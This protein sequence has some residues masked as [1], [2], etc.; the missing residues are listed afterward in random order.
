VPC[1][2]RLIQAGCEFKRWVAGF[3]EGVSALVRTIGRTRVE[4][5]PRESVMDE[6]FGEKLLQGLERVE[7]GA[8]GPTREHLDI[9]LERTGKM[10]ANQELRRA[11]EAVR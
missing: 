6:E 5:N 10:E 2:A 11:G 7:H 8:L 9:R 3:S 1:F 4:R